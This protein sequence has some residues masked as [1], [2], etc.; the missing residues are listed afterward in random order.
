MASTESMLSNNSEFSSS[1]S[2][3]A[4]IGSKIAFAFDIDGVLLRG[5]KNIPQAK[6]ALELLNAHQIPWILLTNGGG[7]SEVDKVN[8]VSRIIGVD[9]EETQLVQSHTPY[10]ALAPKYERVLVVGG[11]DDRCR[12]VAEEVYGFKDVIIPAD[13]VKADPSVWPYHQYSQ[14]D[15]DCIARHRPIY[16]HKNDH[17]KIDA[18]L[19]FSDP[20][21]LGTDLQIVIDLL[22]SKNGY[23]GTKRDLN[24][25]RKAGVNLNTPAVPIYFCNDDLVWMTEHRH[26]RL[27]QGMFRITVE[28]VYEE[29]TQGAKLETT[30]IGKPTAHT[31]RYAENVLQQWR[32]SIYENDGSEVSV[33]MVGDNPA[34]DIKGANKFGWHSVLVR[35]GV[36]KDED[37]PSIA[38][39]PNTIKDN[40]KEA[41][42]YG[43]SYGMQ[44]E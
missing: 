21:D 30:V 8:E 40:V 15:L 27:G 23:I 22:L 32:D 39:M 24:A 3:S 10:R 7:K 12:K 34:S 25:D 11:D 41:V 5:G 1:S 43:I 38:A 36:F 9:I 33:I 31:Y 16:D 19:V 26:P 29:M 44:L 14:E 18:I 2:T 17:T 20:R 28:R 37:L 6:P 4:P 13:I 35:T 42:E